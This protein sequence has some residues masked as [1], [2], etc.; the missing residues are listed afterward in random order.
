MNTKTIHISNNSFTMKYLF[1]SFPFLFLFFLALNANSQLE[2]PED[3]VSW[4]FSVKQNGDEATVVAKIKM[5]KHWHIYAAHLPAGSFT[6]PTNIVFE[7]SDN[8]KVLG[9]IKEPKPIFVHDEE[10][11]EDLYYHSNSIKMSQ[12]IKILSEKDFTLNGIFSFQTCDDSHCLPPYETSFSIKV[13]GTK[14][15]SESTKEEEETNNDV[16]TIVTSDVAK[17]TP[18]ST[19]NTNEIKKFLEEEFEDF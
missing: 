11:D 12:K 2:Y 9:E 4:K 6:I 19:N 8:Y 7:K 13:K 3:K 15:D 10:A 17:S 18:V 16:D 1:K 14:S 5:V